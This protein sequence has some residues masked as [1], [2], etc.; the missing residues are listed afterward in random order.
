MA[1]TIEAEGLVDA[2]PEQVFDYLARLEN[3]WR[4]MDDSVE[5]LSLDGDGDAGPDRGVVRMHGPLGIGRIAHTRVIE[6]ERPLLLRGV[7][8]IGRRMD[9]GRRTEGEVSWRFEPDGGGTRVWLSARVTRAGLADRLLLR[10]GGR[11]WM[12]ARFRLALARLAAG[13]ERLQR[14]S[15]AS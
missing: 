3:H 2:P 10:F 5:V 4:L 14:A 13:S 8:E 7:A 11:R 12:C 1:G 9:G 15:R 6:A